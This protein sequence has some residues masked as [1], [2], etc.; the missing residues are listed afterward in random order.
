LFNFSG[1]KS[2]KSATIWKKV[3]PCT[4]SN[5]QEVMTLERV[6]TLFLSFHP[7]QLTDEAK[8]FCAQVQLTLVYTSGAPRKLSKYTK[9]P[10]A[11]LF[12]LCM[13]LNSRGIFLL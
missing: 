13:G 1:E 7:S 8:S 4:G 2:E 10:N 3:I 12:S 9:R 6:L 11:Y 5:W